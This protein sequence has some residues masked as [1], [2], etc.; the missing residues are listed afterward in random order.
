[1]RILTTPS[2]CR[3]SGRERSAIYENTDVASAIA[4]ESDPRHPRPG[5][6]S[7]CAR[8][9]CRSVRYADLELTLAGR[10]RTR[11]AEHLVCLRPPP[12]AALMRRWRAA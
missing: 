1:M 5:D 3:R 4:R 10:A 8:A 12:A 2:C 9:A 11:L 6:L 7:A